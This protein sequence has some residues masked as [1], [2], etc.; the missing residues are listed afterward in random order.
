MKTRVLLLGLIAS[1]ACLSLTAVAQNPKPPQGSKYK[2][3]F[4]MKGGQDPNNPNNYVAAVT[5]TSS[6]IGAAVRT[7][8]DTPKVGDFTDQLSLKYFF[9]SRTCAGG[10]RVQLAV[11]PSGKNNDPNTGN[12]FGYLGDQAF[13]GGCAQNAWVYE[14]MTDSA[15]KWD[16][17]QFSSPAAAC[18]MTCAWPD[19]VTYFKTNFPNHKVLN[20][21]LADDSCSFAPTACGTAYYDLISAGDDSLES[22][23][24]TD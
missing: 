16:L 1:L 13:G 10:T 17:S 4:G 14:D 21:V 7:F 19:V 22:K 2:L 24:D 20:F 3:A 8:S 5:T 9:V 12:A 11:S 18:G 6:V 15:P 23:A